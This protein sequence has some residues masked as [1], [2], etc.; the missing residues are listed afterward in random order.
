MIVI[1]KTFLSL[2]EPVGRLIIIL[3]ALLFSTLLC[4]SNAL[5]QRSQLFFN[6]D[7]YTVNEQQPWVEAV[8]VV[9][10]EIAFVGSV[11]EAKARA[12]AD[13]EMI[14]L[15]GSMLMPGIQDVHMHPLEARSPFAGTCLLDNDETDAENFIDGLIACAPK[16]PASNWV[17]GSGHSVFTLLEAERLPREIL[18]EAIPDRPAL[19]MEETSHSVW[20]NSKALALAGINKNTPD[21][22]GGVIVKDPDSGEPTGVLFDAA[23]DQLMSLAWLPKP[24]IKQLN[25][26]G[27]LEALQEVNAYGITALAEGR[28]YWKR[29]FQDAWLRA[30]REGKLTVRAMLN[31][32]AYP[33]EQDAQQIKRIK[34][35]YRDNP[36]ELV[37]IRQIKA[38]SDGILINSTAALLAP[39]KKTL[40]E[41]P[42]DDGLN[43][44]TQQRLAKYMRALPEF[45]FHIHTI[46]DRG[47]HESL[48]AIASAPNPQAR[49]RLTHLEMV[50]SSDYPRF[51]QLG[52]IADMQVAGAFTQPFHWTENRFLIGQRANNLVP[53]RSL[54]EAGAKI[55]LSSDWDVS[56][57]SP[58]V[59]MQNAL[60]RKPQALP[61]LEAV[62]KAYTLSP[63]Y[64]LRH[65]DKTGSIEVGKQADL[66]VLDRNLFEIPLGEISKTQVLETY[67]AGKRVYA[68]D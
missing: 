66:I 31:L 2:N 62:I 23:G 4:S 44:F 9:D 67:L 28:T 54:H 32:W 17:L 51:K 22:V 53:L 42:S 65:E 12:T 39:Y 6:G 40:G 16:Q 1:I 58:F 5:A 24:D 33:A 27:L 8:Y 49:H 18:D 68:A 11:A 19:I 21:P 7:I 36:D 34:A 43:Y 14:D 29:D 41:I 46:G 56:T 57:L 50:D 26:E 63:A 15:A 52:V 35:L 59:G 25:Y 48:N 55:T 45:D 38:Y 20:V 47:V 3:C 64:A 13:T 30:Q 61:N 10:D 60:T 37:R